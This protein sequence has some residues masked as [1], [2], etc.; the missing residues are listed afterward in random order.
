[1]SEYSPGEFILTNWS[2]AFFECR[3]PWLIIKVNPD[4]TLVS[5]DRWSGNVYTVRPSEIIRKVVPDKNAPKASHEQW[6]SNI[7]VP[8]RIRQFTGKMTKEDEERLK[9]E[10]EER[11]AYVNM[12]AKQLIYPFEKEEAEEH[13][14]TDVKEYEKQR[15]AQ[16]RAENSFLGFY[17]GQG[18]QNLLDDWASDYGKPEDW[19]GLDL[20]DRLLI[21][22]GYGFD[23]KTKRMY[24]K[25]GRVVSKEDVMKL[26]GEEKSF[27]TG[28]YET[29]RD[30]VLAVLKRWNWVFTKDGWKKT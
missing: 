19:H 24:S 16:I 17:V 9:R 15:D 22:Y 28:N 26:E 21:D 6:I 1:M 3:R 18:D 8:F 4:G 14:F 30:I 27:P 7:D 29:D 20:P 10:E 5:W 11:K 2:Q 12:V 13:G 23:E 25:S